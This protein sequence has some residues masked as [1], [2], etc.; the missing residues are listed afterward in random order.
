MVQRR[1]PIEMEKRYIRKDRSLLWVDVCDTPVLDAKGRPVS[2][3]AV[4]IDATQRKKAEVALQKSKKLLEERVREQTRELRAAN[5]ELKA[6]IA[7]R[8]GLEGEILE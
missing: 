3:V 4:A 7:R 1:Q 2:A 6:E 5:E 8:K